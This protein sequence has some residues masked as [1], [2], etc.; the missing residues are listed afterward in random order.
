M[1]IRVLERVSLDLYQILLLGKKLRCNF[2]PCHLLV[3][4]DFY[5]GI[6]SSNHSHF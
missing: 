2:C 6:L 4:L 3:L 5:P 1:N